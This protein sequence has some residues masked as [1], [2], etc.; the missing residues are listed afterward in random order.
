[1]AKSLIPS[2]NKITTLFSS[3]LSK[4]KRRHSRYGDNPSNTRTDIVPADMYTYDMGAMTVSSLLGQGAKGARS[5]AVIYEK[6]QQM[7]SDS[8]ISSALTVQ[9]MSALGGH[10]T[11]GDVVF[12]ETKP[13]FEK[14]KKKSK[15][16]DEIK[17][18]ISSL[19]NKVAVSQ[20][21]LGAAF[22]DAYAR[23]YS[24]NRGVLDISCDEI[25]RPP[26]VQPFERGN[27]TVGYAVFVGERHFEKLD[28][29]QIA[30]LK[31]PRTIWVPQFGVVEKAIRT[32]IT[33]DDLSMLPLLPS[34]V[35]G[36]LLYNAETA[37]D[38]LNAA[39]MAMVSERWKASLDHRI[40][41]IQME[42]MTKDQQIRFKKSVYDMYKQVK[43]IIANAIKTGTPIMEPLISLMP[44]AND[45]QLVSL[46]DG[47]QFQPKITV[48]DVMFHARML[49]GTMGVD[50][51]MLGF[52]DQMPSSLSGDGGMSGIAAQAA[53]KARLIRM[54]LTEFCENIIDIHTYKKYGYVLEAKDKPWD[55]NLYGSIY[56]L[57]AKQQQTRTDA[58]NAGMV[59][60]QAMQMMKEM[61]SDKAIM[62][63]FLSKTL[64]IDEE[65]AKQYAK[66]VDMLP[67]QPPGMGGD[68][69]GG[70]GFGAKPPGMPA[71]A[72]GDE[73]EED[74]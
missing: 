10:H 24:D 74:A 67:K 22:G 15:L 4:S 42:S 71:I 53:E 55:V 40:V 37:Y 72:Q 57:E 26:L 69:F 25:Y 17:A 41:G 59:M 12:I 34:M 3:M 66:I 21:Y 52:A 20:S 5:R 35:G 23:V 27:R 16:V 18:D 14:D 73:E 32:Q 11:T 49:S 1:M 2:P 48:E 38:R 64:L 60:A 70:G 43:D 36:S 51:S 8:I 56:A 50:L 19:L 54:G 13:E 47:N 45:K 62:E 29:T 33:E 58:M 9:V 44:M 31:M 28:I 30:R 39:I 46:S 6:W 68:E 63:T 61:G 7:E 65:L